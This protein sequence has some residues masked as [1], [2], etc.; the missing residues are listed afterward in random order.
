MRLK[1]NVEVDVK[2]KRIETEITPSCVN[3]LVK[4]SEHIVNK[5]F[6][7]ML[8]SLGYDIELTYV[9]HEEE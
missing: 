8:V 5:T 3:W 6:I 9:K 7:Q 4:K 2:V 1:N